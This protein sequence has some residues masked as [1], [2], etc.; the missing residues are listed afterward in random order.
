[1]CNAIGKRFEDIEETKAI[2]KKFFFKNQCRTYEICSI[3]TSKKNEEIIS[4]KARSL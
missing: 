2:I 1:M 4:S 3:E